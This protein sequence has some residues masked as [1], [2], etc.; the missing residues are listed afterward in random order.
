MENKFKTKKQAEKF[1]KEIKH[2][3]GYTPKIFNIEY[4]NKFMVIK[5]RGLK[6]IR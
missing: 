6:K 4:E 1:A 2:Y 5:P 3:Y